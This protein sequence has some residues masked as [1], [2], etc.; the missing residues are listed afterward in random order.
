MVADSPPVLSPA[1]REARWR[2]GV[3]FAIEAADVQ[4]AGTVLGQVLAKL[5][6]GMVLRGQPVIHPRH[7]SIPDGMWIADIQPGLAHLPVIDPDD[8]R[9][10]CSY[11]R[12]HFPM[13]VTWTVPVNAEH[14]ARCEWPQQIWQRE[15]GTDDLL[16]HPALRAVM[17]F[18]KEQPAPRQPGTRADRKTTSGR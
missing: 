13:G 8:A 4:E 7:R 9:T 2:V 3:R 5:K 15:P 10:R 14:E 12:N 11:L 17:I 1:E 16:L 6:P 18:C